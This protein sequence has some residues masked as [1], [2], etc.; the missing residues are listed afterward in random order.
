M[1]AGGNFLRAKGHRVGAALVLALYA[2]TGLAGSAVAGAKPDT[3]VLKPHEIALSSRPVPFRRGNAGQK[4][5]GEMIFRSGFVISSSSPYWGGLS[6]ISISRQGRHAALV[7][8]AGIWARLDL[9]YDKNRLERPMRAQVGPILALKGKPLRRNKDRDAEAITLVRSDKFFDEVLV[10]FED[11]HRVGRFRLSEKDG[12]S[13]PRSYLK[14][15]SVTSRLRGNAG[16]EALAV[17]QGGGLKNSLVAISQSKRDRDGNYLGWL[18][19]GSKISRLRFTPPPADLYRITDAVSLGNGDMLLLER[20]YKFLSV[21][22]RVRYVRQAELVSGRPIKGRVVM[23]ANNHDHR[24]DNM[25][26][27]AAHTNGHGETIV[28]LISDDNFNSFQQ[29]LLMQFALPK[30]WQTA[31]RKSAQK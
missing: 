15:G 4:I 18:V 12:L 16:L 5:F 2:M 25:E 17:L 30:N 10:S 1:G 23:T 24:V 6:G 21:N 29:T 26:G 13:A 9:T 8:D 14:M 11:N 20:R 27:I 7:S 19:R 3:M 31:W 28:T 22:I